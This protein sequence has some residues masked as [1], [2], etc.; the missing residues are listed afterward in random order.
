MSL[1]ILVEPVVSIALAAL[2]FAEIPGPRFYFGAALVT[3]GVI[4][5]L[6]QPGASDREGG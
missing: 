4:L 1:S 6:W 3:C 2:L 5:A